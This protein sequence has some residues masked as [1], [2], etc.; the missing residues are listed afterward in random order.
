MCAAG[1]VR[2]LEDHDGAD[3]GHP[4]RVATFRAPGLFQLM[5]YRWYRACRLTREDDFVDVALF[6][7]I[8]APLFGFLPE[9][10]CISRC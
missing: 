4:C 8:D 5:F 9:V 1:L 3:L 2:T 6:G 10:Q 7:K